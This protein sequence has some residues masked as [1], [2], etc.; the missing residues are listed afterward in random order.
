MRDHEGAPLNIEIIRLAFE[1]LGR[2]PR[3]PG[4]SALATRPRG[5]SEPLSRQ[6]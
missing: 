2:R 1:R 3:R 5:S 4:L 6:S